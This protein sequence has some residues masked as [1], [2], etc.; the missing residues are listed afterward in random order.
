MSS[1]PL[2]AW[3]NSTLALLSTPPAAN[4]KEATA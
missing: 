1:A 4:P 3:V 2:D